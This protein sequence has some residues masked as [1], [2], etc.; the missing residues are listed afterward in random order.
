MQYLLEAIELLTHLRFSTV[1]HHLSG[2]ARKLVLNLPPYDQTSE[3]VFKELRAVY[4]DTQSFL[5]SLADFYE[6][7][8]STKTRGVCLLIC[9]ITGS[10]FESSRGQPK[11]RQTIPRLGLQTYPPVIKRS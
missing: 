7:K 6:Q 10:K 4:G 11:G 5:D 1:V 9:N 8:Q 2:E 3:M